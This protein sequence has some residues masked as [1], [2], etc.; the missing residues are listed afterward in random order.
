MFSHCCL[1]ITVKVPSILFLY[2]WV[3]VQRVSLI[4]YHYSDEMTLILPL[5]VSS[6]FTFPRTTEP[7]FFLPPVCHCSV[8]SVHPISVSKHNSLT[9]TSS[10]FLG[11]VDMYLYVL[12]SFS[13]SHWDYIALDGR[14]VSVPPTPLS[15]SSFLSA[16]CAVIYCDFKADSSLHT[17]C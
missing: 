12:L 5:F 8:I 13:L 2:V 1:F 10:H 17:I 16:N 3:C 11:W 14:H 4:M 6:F 7:Q 15:S 9:L